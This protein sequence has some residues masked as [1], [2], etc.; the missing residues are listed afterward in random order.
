MN[1]RNAAT[2]GGEVTLR[3]NFCQALSRNA[4]LL[5]P[6]KWSAP[7]TVDRLQAGN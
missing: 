1:L 5:Y 2:D 7:L 4:R 3:V 6:T